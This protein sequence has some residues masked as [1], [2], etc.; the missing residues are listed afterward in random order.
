MDYS[1]LSKVPIFKDLSEKDKKHVHEFIHPVTYKKGQFVQLAGE[2]KPRLAVLNRGSVKIIRTSDEGDELV[3]RFLEPGD[4]MGEKDVFTQTAAEHDVIA[5]EDSTFCVLDGSE[6]RN[7]LHAYPDLGVSMLADLSER[8]D[9]VERQN[10]WI[11]QKN[12]EQRVSESLRELAGG[13]ETFTLNVSKKDLAGKI[14]MRPET[15]SRTL[16]QL[17]ESGKITTDGRS[18]TIKE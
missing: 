6:L 10:E 11:V 5:L 13:R 14:G 3:V 4:Y 9:K 12:A 2:Y 16:K 7:I 17:R 8:L 15:F 18:V 1:C